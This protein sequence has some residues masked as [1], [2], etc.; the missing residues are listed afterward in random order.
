MQETIFGALFDPEDDRVLSVGDEVWRVTI[1]VVERFVV[2]GD[3]EC[4]DYRAG[5]GSKTLRY[6][7]TCPESG[8][9][10]VIGKHDLADAERYFEDEG[11]ARARARENLAG[12]DVL[13][14]ADMEPVRAAV[15][16]RGGMRAVHAVLPGNVVYRK[17]FCSYAFAERHAGEAEALAAFEANVEADADARGRAATTPAF[18]DVYGLGDGRW[19][20]APYAWRN[21]AEGPR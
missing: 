2:D 10:D 15:L 6:W 21:W 5:D 3:F 4:E 14:A 11:A 1:D 16:E 8:L 20:S 9:H 17:G 7:I 18:V 19:S 12:W 13:R